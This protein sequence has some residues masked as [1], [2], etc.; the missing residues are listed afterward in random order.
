[1]I[2]VLIVDDE[3]Y[4]VK[5]LLA[6]VRWELIGVNAVFE[7]YH[8]AMARQMLQEQAIDI[9]ICDI[10]MPEG[11]GLELMEWMKGAGYAPETIML[12][13]HAEF[14]YAQKA[15]QLGG[16][17]YLLKPVLYEDLEQVLLRAIGR[18]E[19]RRKVSET[20]EL[21]RKYEE[22]WNQQK[23]L[24]I[25]RFWQDLLEQRILPRRPELERA[26]A[27]YDMEY[28]ELERVRMILV[29]VENWEKPFTERDEE[30]MEF[31][32]GNAAGE[33][34][35]AGHKGN[36]IRDQRGNLIVVFY[37]GGADASG[38]PEDDE[39]LLQGCK[40]YIEACRRFFYAKISC[41]V[42][43]AAP[44]TGVMKLYHTLLHAE[45]E[46]VT[47]PGEV[48]LVQDAGGGMLG[49][50][51]GGTQQL[52]LIDWSDMIEQGDTEGLLA[53]LNELLEA[54]GKERLTAETLTALYHAF[55]QTVYYVLHRRGLS[56]HLLYT[57]TGLAAS[58]QAATRSVPA[59]KGW[60]KDM[61]F[62]VQGLLSA[63]SGDHSVVQK[64]KAHIAEKLHEE[65]SREQLAALVFLNPA[66]LSRLFRKETGMALTD[67]IL[68]ERMRKAADLLVMTDK[69]ISEIA[70]A[71]GYGNFSYFARLFRKVY[72]VTPHDYR[73]NQRRRA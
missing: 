35:M 59:F 55:L 16:C 5:G 48:I 46:N 73:K 29:S 33:L 53:R 9:M 68:Q 25:E 56:A 28:G 64:I 4:A 26:L 37:M 62:A 63:R 52:S 57:E 12:T 38:T 3:I 34:L 31:A 43:Q 17:D 10:E 61:A 30:I 19:A 18:V 47:R 8:S 49:D 72:D 20:D 70:D 27:S 7:A 41:Y 67:Y 1:M 2:R 66:Y 45:Y 50:A 44:I 13:C 39:A 54:L 71:L 21:Y 51:A 58:G 42:S 14:A 65:L 60:V 69:S 24:L 32:L 22:R 11:S 15:L 23:P 40:T 6:G 36:V